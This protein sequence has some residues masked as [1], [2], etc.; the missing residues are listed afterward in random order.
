MARELAFA[1]TLRHPNIVLVYGACLVGNVL[2]IVMEF[3]DSGSLT[4]VLADHDTVS[5]NN[6]FFYR[7]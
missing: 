2:W 1:T 6:N 7:M 3:A 5:K 4:S